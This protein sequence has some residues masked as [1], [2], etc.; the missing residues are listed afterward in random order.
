MG[1]N[2]KLKDRTLL[3]ADIASPE[4]SYAEFSKV[5]CKKDVKDIINELNFGSKMLDIYERNR[6]N[7]H[8]TSVVEMLK[9]ME[10]C[11]YA[12]NKERFE[13]KMGK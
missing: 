8:I 4:I 6:S 2:F 10:E 9:E 1:R 13:I 5:L 11:F 12:Y 7:M 3:N